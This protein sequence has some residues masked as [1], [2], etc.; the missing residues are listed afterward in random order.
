[1]FTT[2]IQELNDAGIVSIAV[3]LTRG[4]N[5]NDLTKMSVSSSD[6]IRFTGSY[7][8]LQNQDRVTDVEE[9]VCAIRQKRKSM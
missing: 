5:Q 4:S 3:G 9:I 7:S 2:S 1:M 8:D 6:N